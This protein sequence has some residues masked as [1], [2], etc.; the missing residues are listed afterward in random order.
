MRDF[1]D[2]FTKFNHGE[3]LKIKMIL[4]KEGINLPVQN[5]HRVSVYKSSWKDLLLILRHKEDKFFF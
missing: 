1:V 5:T 3:N 2:C 4:F